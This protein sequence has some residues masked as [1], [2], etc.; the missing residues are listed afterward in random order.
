LF[1]NRNPERRHYM[2]TDGAPS[3][4]TER[5]S[6]APWL[7]FL[8]GILAVVVS[9]AAIAESAAAREID[10]LRPVGAAVLVAM[11]L[12]RRARQ[13]ADPWGRLGLRLALASLVAYGAIEEPPWESID[14][15]GITAAAPW[16]AIA[17]LGVFL[18][19]ERDSD[20]ATAGL[21]AVLIGAAFG[22]PFFVRN[23]DDFHS[24]HALLTIAALGAAS[25]AAGW[26]RAPFVGLAAAIVLSGALPFVGASDRDRHLE[27]FLRVVA[28]FVPLV[29]AASVP[30]DS[31]PARR[32]MTIAIVASAVLAVVAAAYAILEGATHF[33]LTRAVNVRLPL[34]GEHPN[35]ISPYF[36]VLAPLVLAVVLGAARRPQR[37]ALWLL[38]GALLA[39]L[40]FTRSRAAAGGAVLGIAAFSALSI[41]APC[42]NRFGSKLTA[43]VFLLAIVLCAAGG[44]V[45]RD[46]I[47]AKLRD[48]SM[49]F[50]IYMWETAVDAIRDRPLTG[51]G[52]LASEP[53]M[54]H[55]RES[56]LDARSKDTHPHMQPLALAMGGG[57]LAALLYLGLLA[58]LLLRCAR[59]AVSSAAPRDR[60]LAAGIA[61][62]AIALLGSNLLDQGLALATAIPLHLGHLLALF[63]AFLANRTVAAPE[64]TGRPG[65]VPRLA[66]GVALLLVTADAVAARLAGRAR[67]ALRDRDP[68]TAVRFTT[69]ATRLDPLDRDIRF[70]HADA[71][72]R[73]GD[74]VA[75]AEE[76]ARL[77]ELMPDSP[78]PWERLGNLEFD[79][80]NLAAAIAALTRAIELDPTGPSTAQWRLRIGGICAELGMREDAMRH[81]A[82]AVRYDFVAAK[83]ANWQQDGQKEYFIPCGKG[84]V[85]IYLTGLMKRNRDLLPELVAKD[86]IKARRLATTLVRIE[87]SFRRYRAARESI[88]FYRS[89]TAVPW[90]PLDH[91]ENEIAH[92]EATD[93]RSEATPPQALDETTP[94]QP[95]D[96]T[97]VESGSP[98]DE[99]ISNPASANGVNRFQDV[100]G[101]SILYVDLARAELT[102]N[103]PPRA[104]ELLDEGLARCY[105]MVSEREAIALLLNLKLDAEIARG[106]AA[107]VLE[108]ADRALYFHPKPSDRIA[109]RIKL[110]SF[111]ERRNDSG[112]AVESLRSS[113]GY[114][115]LIGPER[116]QKEVDSI[117]SLAADLLR[118]D[119][120]RSPTGALLDELSTTGHGLTVAAIAR[121][122]A[123][124]S[125]AG[126]LMRRLR[127]D[128][129]E[130]LPALRLGK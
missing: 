115:A 18:V 83:R 63:V 130:W 120:T 110:G 8:A 17:A 10:W 119:A 118:E 23:G 77:T 7:A 34:F 97:A 116:A 76:L 27:G 112:L 13:D 125:A 127:S 52:L 57:V 70:A 98:P 87:M 96:S 32:R 49:T 36:A 14:T 117:A 89:L 28:A 67:L 20:G 114:L 102:N 94:D 42:A 86:P 79:R 4:A 107:A 45:L 93:T 9:G 56:E 100:A 91:L 95:P 1:G 82:D 6:F 62:S 47:A 113:L 41:F 75:A 92:F 78:Y 80:R 121:F 88:D 61:A 106:D 108:A 22:G 33:D 25:V 39:A 73:S 65:L 71:I 11:T 68:V 59:I 104:I 85:P 126:E 48:P 29:L 46:R 99:T 31:D 21:I 16:L 109:N 58:L 2:A 74:R 72:D 30:R 40:A 35:I 44:F 19:L 54:N 50:R 69:V 90:L 84:E 43:R 5:S 24:L 129:P 124:D 66:L 122:K 123:G 26:W 128:F 38:A 55:A 37:V 15:F 53:L 105:D 60:A 101:E 81:L 103:N 12:I 3:I 51:Y 111:L 64:P